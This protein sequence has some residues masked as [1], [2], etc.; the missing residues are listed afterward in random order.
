MN[1][2]QDPTIYLRIMSESF[3]L[4]NVVD[5]VINYYN[6]NKNDTLYYQTLYCLFRY[7][8]TNAHVILSDGS[9]FKDDTLANLSQQK[10]FIYLWSQTPLSFA[11]GY[12]QGIE[13]S[14][15]N[16]NSTHICLS[17]N[18]I[19]V[20][21]DCIASMLAIFSSQ[22]DVGCV[23]PYLSFSDYCIQNDRFH[24]RLRVCDSMTLNCNLFSKEVLNKIQQVPEYLSGYFNDV[25]MFDRLKKLGKKVILCDAG[26]VIHIGQATVNLASSASMQKDKLIFGERYPE[27]APVNPNIEVKQ[28]ILSDHVGNRLF[29]ILLEN[30][31]SKSLTRLLL[32]LRS[33]F[34]RLEETIAYIMERVGIYDSK[35]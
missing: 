29:Y 30:Q 11:Q 35:K 25:V 13:Y 8:Q 14:Q 5:V 23:I 15:V 12:N 28:S 19:F 9:G 10:G 32:G 3:H 27:L 6:P 16:T 2:S 24:K 18:D 20:N 34:F 22:E 1:F 21:P 17:A 33:V 4:E 26:L 31:S 7:M